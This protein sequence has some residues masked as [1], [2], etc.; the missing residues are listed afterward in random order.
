M[1]KYK[2]WKRNNKKKLRQNRLRH[3][4]NKTK[5]YVKTGRGGQMGLWAYRTLV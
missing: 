1:L 2:E 4:G 5:R 3:S